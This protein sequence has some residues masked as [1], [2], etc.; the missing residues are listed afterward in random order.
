M[1]NLVVII[2]SCVLLACSTKK[3]TAT[4]DIQVDSIAA[5]AVV[6][7][8]VERDARKIGPEKPSDQVQIEEA[9]QKLTE[10]ANDPLVG[11]WVGMFGKNKINIAIAEVKD[12]NA[13][14]YTVCAGNFRPIKGT[15]KQVDSLHVFVMDE[16]GA[17]KYD[18]HFE[19]SINPSKQVLEGSWSPF[20]KGIVGAK[21]YVL[22]KIAYIYDVNTG[23]YPQ[24]SIRFL[25]DEDVNNM[26]PEELEFMRN[27]IY[28]RHGYSFKDIEDRRQF[29]TISWYIPMGIDIRDQLTDI[30]V[31]NIDLI[32][33]YENYLDE[34]YDEYGR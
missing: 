5:P 18:G 23:S 8:S 34:N 31:E 26:L 20:K 30:E 9:I 32:Y 22:Q 19:F 29:D 4:N 27:E 17:D 25:E 16:P 33:R 15:A 7:V 11:Y 10:N 13:I 2:V 14:G 28:A 6:E 24:A 21:K 12:G 3:E 1:K